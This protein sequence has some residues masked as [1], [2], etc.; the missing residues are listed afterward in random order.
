M[1]SSMGRFSG[2]MAFQFLCKKAVFLHLIDLTDGTVVYTCSNI[3]DKR[4]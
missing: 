3:R 4:N 2:Q 1:F